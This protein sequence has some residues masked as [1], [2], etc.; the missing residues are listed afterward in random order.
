MVCGIECGNFQCICG[1]LGLGAQLS[2]NRHKSYENR[3]P[4]PEFTCH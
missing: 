1:N 4:D 2:R 3:S